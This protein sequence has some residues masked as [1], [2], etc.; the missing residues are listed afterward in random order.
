MKT[1]IL[2]LLDVFGADF[3][4]N[5]MFF[6]VLVHF[7]C[8]TTTCVF[9]IFYNG[10]VSVKTVTLGLSTK[11]GTEDG[12]MLDL[13]ENERIDTET[14]EFS[15]EP[16]QSSSTSYNEN[17]RLSRNENA[18]KTI[19][20]DAFE[21]DLG[22]DDVKK[23]SDIDVT[24]SNSLDNLESSRSPELSDS[25]DVELADNNIERPKRVHVEEEQNENKLKP[26]DLQTEIQKSGSSG[27]IIIDEKDT[28]EIYFKSYDA[29]DD[30]LEHA[31]ELDIS[32]AVIVQPS[33]TV[34]IKTQN[35][36]KES[37]SKKI[38]AA[39]Q[40][41]KAEGS[42]VNYLHHDTDLDLYPLSSDEH[43]NC[44][45]RCWY[46]ERCNACIIGLIDRIPDRCLCP[47][48]LSCYRC[49]QI[50]LCCDWS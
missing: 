10:Y 28:V 13:V 5:R 14:Q 30:D 35:D 8:Q 18:S 2:M 31:A 9:R 50:V 3:N 46:S 25:R 12:S 22:A 4:L 36:V 20:N 19:L 47:C 1:L 34:S 7:S 38:T 32:S 16:P 37:D 49:L 42:D 39:D 41:D 43:R 44:C 6:L 17:A 29:S 27:S 21:L 40:N 11:M 48:L 45:Y 33:S 23:L 26:P 24:Q 15:S